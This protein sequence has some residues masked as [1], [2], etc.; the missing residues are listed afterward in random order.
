[1]ETAFIAFLFVIILVAIFLIVISS[2]IIY[3][4]SSSSSASSNNNT[5]LITVD[6]MIAWHSLPDYITSELK[7]YQAFKKLG[8]EFTNIHN[9][10]Q[11]CSASR[12]SLFTSTINVGIS[13]D[14]QESYQN[15]IFPRVNPELDTIG[16]IYKRN[17]Y[18]ITAFYG[19]SHMDASL[20]QNYNG[21]PVFGLNTRDSMKI[22]GFDSFN[23]LGDTAAMIGLVGDC[24]EFESILSPNS[25]IYDYT[26]G[27]NKYSGIYPFLK[28]RHNDKKSFHAQYHMINPHDTQEFYQNYTITPIQLQTQM[29][30]PFI[31]EQI[32]DADNNPFNFNELYQD[33]WVTYPN[34]TSN[35]FE[36]TYLDYS[37]N[38]NSLPFLKS[39]NDDYVTSSKTNSII[40]FF[41]GTQEFLS[42]LFSMPND[43]TDIKRW[44]NLINNYY[45]LIFETDEYIWK[46]Y[47]Y[48]QSNG[49]L[50]TTSVIISGDHGDQ[51]SSH[52]L[53]QKGFPFKE[54]QNVPFLVYS[55]NLKN[56][57]TT[58]DILGSLLDLNP[59]FEVISNLEIKSDRFSG[60]SL[61]EWDDSKLIS[62]TENLNV[63][64]VVN[65]TMHLPSGYIGYKI[66]KAKN[67]LLSKPYKIYNDPQNIFY[68]RYSYI[69][70]ITNIKGK[71]YKFCRYYSLNQLY[72][73]NYKDRIILRKEFIKSYNPPAWIVPYVNKINT[74][75]PE[76]FSYQDIKRFIIGPDT[77]LIYTFIILLMSFLNKTNVT[78]EY[79][80][81]GIYN[82]YKECVLDGHVFT[83]WNTTDDY[84]E[85]I[86][87]T[88]PYH[89]ERHNNNLFETLNQILNDEALKHGMDSLL[90][91]VPVSIQEILAK[92]LSLFG[93]DLENYSTMQQ[94]SFGQALSLSVTETDFT[95]QYYKDTIKELIEN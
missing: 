28:A 24:R 44:K 61:L 49:M 57:G 6:Q 4:N 89:P 63:F 68:F 48:L 53:K 75:L 72:E 87:L 56:P 7:G 80:V 82:T 59:T 93:N 17:G 30:S 86:N 3:S 55:P 43:S 66:W 10:R 52:G 42:P 79:I 9:N 50:K 76:T 92:C 81:P 38:K 14:I 62:R 85:I 83:C 35:Y 19:K 73:T 32:K 60:K 21:L 69:S 1:M 29:V 8:I 45:G 88:D 22:Y 46:I 15:D 64:S 40:P 51:M 91:P 95:Y 26:D 78:N 58:C 65:S 11:D 16:K 67:R 54:S 2:L 34:L 71:Q 12:S 13:D 47:N 20:S 5:L 41:A 94:L 18:D 23:I 25:T 37:N 70:C 31:A 33:A 84:D 90:F 39:Y 77:V 74:L 36:D 27:E